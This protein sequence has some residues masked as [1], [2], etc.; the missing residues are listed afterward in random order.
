[1]RAEENR[2]CPVRAYVPARASTTMCIAA[3]SV[4]KRELRTPVARNNWKVPEGTRTRSSRNGM[5]AFMLPNRL[6]IPARASWARAG[7]A[8]SV[9]E[10]QAANNT[11]LSERSLATCGKL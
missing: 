1:M 2:S 11:K 6:T 4:P 8:S 10:Y 7:S 5:A 3:A 9:S